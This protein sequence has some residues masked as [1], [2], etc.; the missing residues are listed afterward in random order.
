[1]SRPSIKTAIVVFVS[2]L[3]LYGASLRS[4]QPAKMDSLNPDRSRGIL[5]DAYENVKKH[6]LVS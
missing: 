6:W 5:R 1:V 3:A 4:Q 2:L